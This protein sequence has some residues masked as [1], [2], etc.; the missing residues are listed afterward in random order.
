MKIRPATPSDF[1]TIATI[2]AQSWQDTYADVL[3]ADYLTSQ[4][5]IDFKQY[6]LEIAMRIEGVILVAEDG[7]SGGIIGFIAIWCQPD[8][9][10]DN[11]H[12][13]SASR[14]RGVGTALMKAA[15]QKL[16]QQDHKTA[17]LWVVA[18]NVR[19]IRFYERLGG[20]CGQKAIK[21]LSGH[22]VLMIK[23]SWSDISVIVDKVGE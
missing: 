16:I 17:Y 14:S 12:I 11:L 5:F 3:S 21:D 23:M 8:P 9:L 6:W 22:D 10:I 2:H 20:I 4:V 7:E 1:P 15:A 19:A 13:K 18:K